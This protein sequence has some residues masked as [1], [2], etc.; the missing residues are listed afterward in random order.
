MIAQVI[1]RAPF[2]ARKAITSWH[3]QVT[4]GRRNPIAAH[5]NNNL[6]MNADERAG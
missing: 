6:V 5:D 2:E 4:F 1:Q 3:H